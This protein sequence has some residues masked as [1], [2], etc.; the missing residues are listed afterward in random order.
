MSWVATISRSQRSR[1]QSCATAFHPEPEVWWASMLMRTCGC[2]SQLRRPHADRIETLDNVADECDALLRGRVVRRPVLEVLL[3]VLLLGGGKDL[4]AGMTTIISSPA[5]RPPSRRR[6]NVRRDR[7]VDTNK[8][9]KNSSTISVSFAKMCDDSASALETR[10][11]LPP[12]A[13]AFVLRVT[14]RGRAICASSPTGRA[15]GVDAG[16]V[17]ERCALPFRRAGADL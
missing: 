9:Q 12:P 17:G 7:L 3:R 10:V 11:S 4:V 6:A 2:T 15:P 1:K 8:G 14:P 16:G 5:F 13:S